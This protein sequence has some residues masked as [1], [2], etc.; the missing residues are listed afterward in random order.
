M[1]VPGR[2]LEAKMMIG[3][4]VA[5]PCPIEAD[6]QKSRADDDVEAMKP[7]RHKKGR[8]VNAACKVKWRMAVFVCLD[9]GEANS[10]K[11]GQRQAPQQPVAVALNQ[12]VMR[13]SDRGS[14]Q[15]QDQR[16]EKREF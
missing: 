16:V 3:L 9:R 4:E 1:P 11:D 8:R 2:G 10:K 13:P 5:C 12:R 14:R 15:Q 6:D 7:R